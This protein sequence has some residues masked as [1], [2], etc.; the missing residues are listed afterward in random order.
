[1]WLE[2]ELTWLLMILSVSTKHTCPLQ[3]SCSVDYNSR[4]RREEIGDNDDDTP[5]SEM[6]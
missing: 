6:R 3:R 1:M 5:L 4:N 2:T